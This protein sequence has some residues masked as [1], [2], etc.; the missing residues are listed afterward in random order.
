MQDIHLLF[1]AVG[2]AVFWNFFNII[3]R[4]GDYKEN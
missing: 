3:D 2:M 1:Y 4:G